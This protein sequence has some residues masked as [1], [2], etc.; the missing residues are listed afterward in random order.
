M[1]RVFV[2]VRAAGLSTAECLVF[3]VLQCVGLLY[4]SVC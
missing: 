2:R 1:L 3:C 4:V